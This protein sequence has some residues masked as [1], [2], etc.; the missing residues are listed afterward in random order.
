MAAGNGPYPFPTPT[1]DAVQKVLYNGVTEAYQKTITIKNNSPNEWLY[2]FLEGEIARQAVA[3]YEGTGAFDP[4]D[5]VNQEYRGYVGYTD[6][7]H[8]YAG[9]PPLTSITITVP[10]AFWDSGRIVFSTD[11]ADQF[12]TFG[13]AD[14][15]SPAGAP[16]Y[17]F[18]ANTQATFFGNIDAS[19]PDRLSFTPIYN[20][21]DPTNGG[22]PT[23][24]DWKSP[25]ASG[26]FQN[27]QVL[28]VTGPGLPA[29]GSQVTVD[30]SHP[31][32]LTLPGSV[33][34]PQSAQEYT[35]TALTGD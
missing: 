1:V 18:D 14:G 11:G 33:N 34:Q 21:F 29:G 9:L 35:F 7:A 28:V 20:G 27:G 22:K 3:P 16:F 17:Y 24:N 25:V 31:D 26:Q 12:S 5:S 13:G 6:G 23:T 4:Y 2:A 8:D 10:L 32:Y 30:A 15:G 19:H